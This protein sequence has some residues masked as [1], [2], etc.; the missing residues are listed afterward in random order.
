APRRGGAPGALSAPGWPL[1]Y[2]AWPAHSMDRRSERRWHLSCEPPRREEH[3]KMD[4]PYMQHEE[5]LFY[6]RGRPDTMLPRMASRE[7]WEALN[8]QLS[9]TDHPFAAVRAP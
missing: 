4:L 2:R 7:T 1:V 5:P 8:P 3:V 6:A 9:V